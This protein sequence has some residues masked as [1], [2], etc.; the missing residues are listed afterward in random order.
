MSSIIVDID[1]RL[2]LLRRRHQE[3]LRLIISVTLDDL[4]DQYSEEFKD[5]EQ[6]I[7]ATL[8]E[9]RI[10][11]EQYSAEEKRKVIVEQKMRQLSCYTW[12]TFDAWLNEILTADQKDTMSKQ[13]VRYPKNLADRR[14]MLIMGQVLSH[15]YE[16]LNIDAELLDQIGHINNKNSTVSMII[17]YIGHR[18]DYDQCDKAALL[19]GR[20]KPEIPDHDWN[21]MEFD[22]H[23]EHDGTLYAT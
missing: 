22:E 11:E 19:V 21:D 1:K 17:N 18:D 12:Q 23:D 15:S 6:K 4:K 9:R 20:P 14:G 3:L 13:R 7:N 5:V 2:A 8:E 16:I 10:A